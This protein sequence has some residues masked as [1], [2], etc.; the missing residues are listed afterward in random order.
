MKE[1]KQERLFIVIPA[2]NEEETIEF[3][4]AQWH[5]VVECLKNNS[6]ILVVNDGSKD[7]TQ[8]KLLDLQKRYSCLEVVE[9]VNEGHGAAILYGYRYAIQSGADYIFQTDSDGQTIPDE[10]WT[11]W[12]ERE[13]CGLLIG[14][15]KKRQDGWQRII[16]TR[17]LRM[18]LQMIFKCNVQDANTPFRL[19]RAEELKL[20]LKEI[21]ERYFLANVL[22]TVIY[23]KRNMGVY[24]YP[25]TFLPR[26]GGKNSI[27]MRRIADIG[28]HAMID[29]WKMRKQF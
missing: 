2:Y 21:P 23:T 10:F 9:K 25:I 12:K 17:V 29:F 27:N 4:V 22:M 24:Y 26:Q 6:R 11:L 16:V 3:V 14:N 7:H 18:I 13:K 15:R 19:M 20:V 5:S 28:K 8:E 1:G